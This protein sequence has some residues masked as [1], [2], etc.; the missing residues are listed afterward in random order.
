M[1]KHYGAPDGDTL[2][3]LA[4]SWTETDLV[5]VMIAHSRYTTGASSGENRVVADEQ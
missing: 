5:R 4:R 1:T 3:T 2:A